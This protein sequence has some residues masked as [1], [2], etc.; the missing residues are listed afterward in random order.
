MNLDTEIT[1]I[2]FTTIKMNY[3][4]DNYIFE[5]TYLNKI[6][7]ITYIIHVHENEIRFVESIG[8]VYGQ[9]TD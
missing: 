5:T 3:S 4:Q 1:K 8:R 2:T 7:C 6:T 9:S